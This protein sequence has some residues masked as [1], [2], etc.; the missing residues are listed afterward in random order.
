[1]T[2]ASE[3]FVEKDPATQKY[4]LGL[5]VLELAGRMTSRYDLRH[6]AGSYMDELAKKLDEIIN[7]GWGC[8]E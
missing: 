1:M 4:R 3:G 5:K 8:G 2:L 7:K 6:L